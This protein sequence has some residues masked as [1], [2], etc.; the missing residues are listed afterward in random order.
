[1]LR[2]RENPGCRPQ[3]VFECQFIPFSSMSQHNR[4]YRTSKQLCKPKPITRITCVLVHKYPY[5]RYMDLQLLVGTG[6][7][8]V[9]GQL[10][11]FPQV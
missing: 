5:L 8:C 1:M 3:A 2:A 7:K 6:S 10:K 11:E 9:T 4:C